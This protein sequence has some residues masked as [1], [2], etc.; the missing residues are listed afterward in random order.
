MAAAVLNQAAALVTV[1]VVDK[2]EQTEQ[3]ELQ[4]VQLVIKQL[5]LAPLDRNHQV[6]DQPEVVEVVVI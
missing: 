4:V 6:I 2:R 3:V 5:Q 1:V